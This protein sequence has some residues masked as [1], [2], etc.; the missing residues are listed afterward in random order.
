MRSR[1]ETHEKELRCEEM[2]HYFTV[3]PSY[4]TIGE[5][6]EQWEEMI[7][8]L[9]EEYEKMVGKVVSSCGEV[10]PCLRVMANELLN[11]V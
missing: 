10:L 3:Q 8:N 6:I 7:G 4:D 1:E 9:E 11:D 5:R 2:Q